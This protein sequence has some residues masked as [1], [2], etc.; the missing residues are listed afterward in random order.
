MAQRVKNKTGIH[1]DAGSISDLTEWVKYPVLPQGEAWIWHC[2]VCSIGSSCS[3]NLTPS[4][5]ISICCRCRLRETESVK[6]YPEKWEVDGIDR[7]PPMLQASPANPLKLAGAMNAGRPVKSAACSP[8]ATSRGV[9]QTQT[10]RQGDVIR[11]V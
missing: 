5:E 8:P 10:W 11:R 1:E 2:C 4:L 9:M 7:E 6:C 3:A